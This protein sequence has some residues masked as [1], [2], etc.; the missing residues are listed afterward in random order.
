VIL[1]SLTDGTRRVLGK[2]E[3]LGTVTYSPTGHLLLNFVT[4]R[5]RIL[6]VPFSEQKLAII[7]DPFLVAAGGQFPSVSLNGNMIYSISSSSVLS[8]LVWVDHDGR[9]GRVV[10][11]P[12]LG[13]SDPAI[14]P[15][16]NKV[17]VVARENENADIWIED[18]ARG[19]RT[20]VVSG[21][22]NEYAP[23]WSKAGDRLYYLRE[24]TD[25]FHSIM[26]VGLGGSAV[27]RSHVRGVELPPITV[28]P[29][30]RAVVF[31]VEKEGTINLWSKD[32]RDGME[33]IRISQDP[34]ISEGEPAFS[35]DGRWL[36]YVSEETGEQEVF[37]RQFPTGGEKVQVSLNGGVRPSCTGKPAH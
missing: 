28:S 14:S 27:P 21:P 2:F 1:V 29:D 13:L 36:A 19:T 20:K 18:L 10:G 9:V 37:V 30:D 16:G 17:A 5:R 26:E 4:G 15:D 11:R 22:Q 6:A 25:L 35:P 31:M 12:R 33:P 7:G 23:I 32:L 8:E 3:G 24:E 34:S